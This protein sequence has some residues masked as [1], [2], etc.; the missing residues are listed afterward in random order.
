MSPPAKKPRTKRVCAVAVCPNPQEGVVYHSFPKDAQV[1]KK[2][3]TLTRRADRVNVV[4]ARICS[5]HFRPEDYVHDEVSHLYPDIRRRLKPDAVPSQSLV[6]SPPLSDE[7][8][9]GAERASLRSHRADDGMSLLY[10]YYLLDYNKTGS[11][12]EFHGVHHIFD[13]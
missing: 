9:A 6:C 10:Y 11:I 3:L 1:Q 4:S 8:I 12:L 7:S 13:A 2:W 5:Q